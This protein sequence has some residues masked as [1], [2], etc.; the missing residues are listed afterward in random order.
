MVIVKMLLPNDSEIDKERFSGLL[1]FSS[2]ILEKKFKLFASSNFLTL[3]RILLTSISITLLIYI[4]LF[5][6]FTGRT[7]SEQEVIDFLILFLGPIFYLST[8]NFKWS[9]K[10]ESYSKFFQSI[11]VAGAGL[12]SITT[13]REHSLLGILVLQLT[14]MHFNLQFLGF[15]TLA[16]INL[17]AF[18]IKYLV[19][20]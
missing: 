14:S 11:L 1:K 10:V 8:F 4:A 20:N 7:D 2:K 15:F 5:Y 16:V 6:S 9:Q 18:A 3:N 19:L 17:V 13:N 12:Y